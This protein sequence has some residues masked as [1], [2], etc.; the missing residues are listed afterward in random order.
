M[1]RIA[2]E[3]YLYLNE[4]PNKEEKI[5]I[6]IDEIDSKF[7]WTNREKYFSRLSSFILKE[8]PQKTIKFVISTHMSETI[9]KL[10]EGYSIIKFLDAKD[11]KY[12]EY[13][14][15]DFLNLEQVERIS[16]IKEYNTNLV[17]YSFSRHFSFVN[18]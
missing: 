9:S 15:N 5:L 8:F 10:P 14:S 13:H 3:I 4:E 7:Y 16:F 2:S 6:F 1:I 12:K 17:L 11:E 18:I